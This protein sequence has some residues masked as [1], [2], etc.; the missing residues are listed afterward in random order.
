MKRRRPALHMRGVSGAQRLSQNLP[1]Q[2]VTGLA[3]SGRTRQEHLCISAHSMWARSNRR[4]PGTMYESV[5]DEDEG[6]REE[7]QDVSLGRLPSL[8]W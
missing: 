6:G 2:R 5:E 7:A 3:Q 1:A 4:P 8:F